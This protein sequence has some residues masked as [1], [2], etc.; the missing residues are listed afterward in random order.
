M[1]IQTYL[2]FDY[3]WRRLGIAVGEQ[4]T[5]GARPLTTLVCRQG[6]PEWQALAGLIEAWR[7]AALV[8]GIPRHADGS[9]SKT[10]ARAIAFAKELERRWGLPTHQVDE[11]L[12]SHEARARLQAKGRRLPGAPGKALIDRL[13]AQI[14]LETWLSEQRLS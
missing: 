13:A 10:T 14:I 6:Q 3:G 2:G 7:P 1:A 4:L 8:V 11:R 5:G 9:A 12:S